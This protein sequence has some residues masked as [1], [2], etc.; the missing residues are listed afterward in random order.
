MNLENLGVQEMNMNELTAVDG[1]GWLVDAN[2]YF[3]ALAFYV[4]GR[5]IDGVVDGAN[6][7]ADAYQNVHG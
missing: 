3:N 5:V 7:V 1:G 2:I 6:T 4:A